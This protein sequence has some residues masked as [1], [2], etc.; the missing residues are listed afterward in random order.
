MRLKLDENLGWI[1]FELFRK[2]GHEVASVPEQGLCS[3]PD[4]NLI[5][6]CRRERRCLVT[7]DM[8]FGNPLVFK[9]SEYGGIAVLRLPPKPTHADLVDA[10]RTLIGAL[11]QSNVEG[12]LWI[13]Q[14]GRIREYQDPTR[15]DP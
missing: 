10:I 15:E 4:R 14:R 8:E 11:R 1:A 13:V 2:A 9:P 12:R 5:E 7:L 3:A 6:I